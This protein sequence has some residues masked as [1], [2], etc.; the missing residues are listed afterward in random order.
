MQEE[1]AIALFFTLTL[2]IFLVKKKN[3]K[4]NLA[5]D[6]STK[7]I[8]LTKYFPKIEWL[9]YFLQSKDQGS[10]GILFV[11]HFFW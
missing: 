5:L 6:I 3:W 11:A 8:V 7:L 2:V 4:G 1:H 10:K 9:N